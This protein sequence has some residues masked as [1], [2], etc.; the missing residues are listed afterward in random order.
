ML[1]YLNNLSILLLELHFY[2][3]INPST[4]VIENF[5]PRKHP[6]LSPYKL[7]L[8]SYTNKGVTHCSLA[9]YIKKYLKSKEEL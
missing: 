6:P 9:I 3:F 8:F 7:D 1:I 4:Y 5:I 2:L